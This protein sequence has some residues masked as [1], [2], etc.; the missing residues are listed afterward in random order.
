[1]T[2]WMANMGDILALGAVVVVFAGALWLQ[3]HHRS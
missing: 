1:M 3:A 2:A